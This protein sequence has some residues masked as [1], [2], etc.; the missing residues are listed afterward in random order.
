MNKG[1]L[2]EKLDAHA[3]WLKTRDTDD[4]RGERADLRDTDLRGAD[5]RD[6]DLRSAD[7]SGTNLTGVDLRDADL[8]DAD[9][10]GADL[11]GADLHNAN[12]CDACLIGANLH[13]V[14]LC[15]AD[16]HNANLCDADLRGADLRGADLS[17]ADLRGADLD[18][19]AWP[20]SCWSLSVKINKHIAAQLL[21]HALRAMQSCADDSDVAAVLANDANIQLS[22]QFHR[23]DECGEINPQKEGV[24]S[25]QDIPSHGN[26]ADKVFHV[27]R[28]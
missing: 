13:N 11:R 21:Y 5:L 27:D 6:T 22:N 18:F 25:E 9:L 10:S 24:R 19:S 4:V 1:E 8:R 26:R 28:V 12:L 17:L 20:F 15:D 14:N 23:V 2:K 7:L 3:L 16:L